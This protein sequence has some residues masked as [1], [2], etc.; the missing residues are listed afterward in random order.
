MA[1]KFKGSVK[2]LGAYDVNTK[3]PLDNRNVVQKVED[4]YKIEH[5]YSYEGMPVTVIDEGA[6]YVLLDDNKRGSPD[7]WSKIAAIEVCK[8]ANDLLTIPAKKAFI[9]ML[10]TVID[11]KAVY[12]LTKAPINMS[13]S[14]EKVTSAGGAY[15]TRDDLNES[16]IREQKLLEILK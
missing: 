10:V 9:G 14:W 13:D 11:E 5:F 12:M 3:R 15:L 1:F 4:L 8:T 16:Y 6:I 7:G 2:I